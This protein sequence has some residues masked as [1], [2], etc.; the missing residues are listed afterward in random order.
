MRDLGLQ[1]LKSIKGT[2]TPLIRLEELSQNFPSHASVLS[3]LK[4]KRESRQIL[5]VGK[6]NGDFRFQN[7]RMFG[8]VTIAFCTHDGLVST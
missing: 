5:R 2:D 1:A 4:I 3:A 6:V 8:L 7:V